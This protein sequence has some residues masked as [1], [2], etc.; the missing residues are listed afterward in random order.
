MSVVLSEDLADLQNERDER[1]IEIDQV[2][3]TDLKYPIIVLDR[4]QEKQQTVATMT[5]TPANRT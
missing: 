3:I 1:R 5:I 4:Q 2:G